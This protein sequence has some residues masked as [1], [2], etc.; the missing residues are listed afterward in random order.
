MV[1]ASLLLTGCSKEAPAPVVTD[2]PLVGTAEG[3][4]EPKI[5]EGAFNGSQFEHVYDSTNGA[6]SFKKMD[7]LDW[8][9]ERVIQAGEGEKLPEG[10]NFRATSSNNFATSDIV[11]AWVQELIA[12]DG[13]T[14]TNE[15]K[16]VPRADEE[17]YANTKGDYRTKPYSIDLSKGGTT[18]KVKIENETITLIINSK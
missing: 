5:S 4:G 13:W 11:K 17:R 3:L 10:D 2:G 1:A 8:K 12:D 7:A 14:G 18:M 9:I 6:I 16:P 15:V